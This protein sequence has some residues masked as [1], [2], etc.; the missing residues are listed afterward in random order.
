[1]VVRDTGHDLH[2]TRSDRRR[3]DQREESNGEQLPRHDPASR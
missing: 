2:R 3:K 1:M